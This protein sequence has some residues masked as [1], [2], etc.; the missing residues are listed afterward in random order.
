MDAAI[1][2]PELVRLLGE[3]RFSKVLRDSERAIRTISTSG[4]ALHFREG[5]GPDGVPWKPLAH[6]RPQ[7][8]TKPLRDKGILAA[9]VSATVTQGELELSSNSPGAATHQYGA[10]IRPKRGKYLAIPITTES[11]R[12]G[13]PRKN[14]FPRP[15]FFVACRSATNKGLLCERGSDG[16][17]V[18]QYVLVP[19]VT[20]PARPFLGWSQ[21]TLDKITRL[22]ADKCV[23][24]LLE[25][26]K[27][28]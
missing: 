14:K 21:K 3:D 25:T 15:L 2:L 19:S 27:A 22:L 4:V 12:V 7:G 23:Q 16:R 8:G 5:V 28:S 9:S 11:R 18:A 6:P 10:T 20:V 17:L 1:T 13:S 26:F 24:T